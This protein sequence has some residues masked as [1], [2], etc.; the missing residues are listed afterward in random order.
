MSFSPERFCD[1]VIL[2]VLAAVIC[3]VSI[4]A[5]EDC[6]VY[7]APVNVEWRYTQYPMH[8]CSF[9]TS[10]VNLNRHHVISQLAAPELANEPTNIIVLCRSC[11]LV[12]GHKNNW[13]KFNPSVREI[14]DRY[15]GP[16]VDSRLWRESH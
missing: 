13:K 14:C 5:E 9:C 10:K 4:K 12:L 16:P 8:E 1:V 7:G 2:I 3:W 15:G 11:H 6:Y